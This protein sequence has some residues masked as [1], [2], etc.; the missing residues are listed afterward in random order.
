M[1]HE[2]APDQDQPDNQALSKISDFES[3]LVMIETALGIDDLPLPTQDDSMT[4]PVFLSLDALSRQ[5][6]TLSTSTD[7]SLDTISRRVRQLTQDTE[8]LEQ[9]RKSAKQAQEALR[10]QALSPTAPNSRADPTKEISKESYPEDPELTAKVNAL[11]GTLSTIESL[12][13]ML[14]SVLDRLRSLR[15]L[16]ADAATASETLTQVES[17]QEGMKEE[18]ES[19]RK[20][21]EKVEEAMEQ[22][23]QAMKGNTEVVE[24]WVKELEKRLDGFEI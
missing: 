8:K 16:H 3:R 2:P 13:P 21:L 11:Y 14:P 9:A 5:L 10:Q 1:Y 12:A 15:A 24:G 18:L 23:E 7:T 22:G 20:G 4:K 19:W 17:R 6:N